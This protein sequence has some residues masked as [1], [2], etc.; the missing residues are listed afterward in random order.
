[1]HC[2]AEAIKRDAA[3]FFWF[4]L[5][6][7]QLFLAGCILYAAPERDI[8][9]L[10]NS[11]WRAEVKKKVRGG[12]KED[13]CKKKECKANNLGEWESACLYQPLNL[14]VCALARVCLRGPLNS[15][16]FLQ[17]HCSLER[18]ENSKDTLGHKSTT[19]PLCLPHLGKVI[20][21][22]KTISSL[23]SLSLLFS[24]AFSFSLPG[25]YPTLS[26]CVCVL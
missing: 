14:L 10:L 12:E 7:L 19:P 11:D 20:L 4:S 22:C 17:S 8:N 15:K 13:A 9:S 2:H 24:V 5:G 21:S 1:M 25:L 3:V 16:P 23:L 26:L 18:R 6:C